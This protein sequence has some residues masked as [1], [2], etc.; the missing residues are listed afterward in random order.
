[1]RVFH[2]AFLEIFPSFV[3]DVGRV[4]SFI[5]LSPF[6]FYKNICVILGSKDM[7]RCRRL[8]CVFNIRQKWFCPPQV[9][10]VKIIF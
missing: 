4:L 8:F 2:H 9:L 10:N 6:L 3:C 7:E 1:M 5:S